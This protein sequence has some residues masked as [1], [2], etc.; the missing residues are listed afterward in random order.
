[1]KTYTK[2]LIYNFFKSFFLVFLITFCLIFILNL[3]TELDFFKQINVTN[4]FTMYLSLINTPSFIFEMFPFIFLISSQVFLINI[5]EHNQIEIFRYFGLKNIDILK[6][7][8]FCSFLVGI[9]I[10]LIF[11]NFSSSLKKIYLEL[12]TNYTSDNKY[13][14]VITN[15][16]LWIKDKIDNKILIINSLEIENNYLLNSFITEFDDNYKILRNIQS[17]KID[18]EYNT[19]KI[20]NAKVIIDNFTTEEKVLELKSNFDYQKIQTLF[21]NLTSLSI[22]E[23][24]ELKKNYEQLGYS[25]IEVDMHLNKL[26]VAPF[27]FMLMIFFSGTIM[28]YFKSK[29]NNTFKLSLGLFMS[30]LIYYYNNFFYVLGNTEKI[31]IIQSVWMP[32]IFL[33]CINQLM[34]KLI[35]S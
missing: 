14:A 25:T 11:Y 8:C 33:F 7:I 15:N 6:I 10:V 21:S 20:H 19:W 22:F 34:L 1:M 27:H 4:S 28:F 16:G 32:L 18:I 13:L 3:L 5:F 9:A 2:F 17:E 24:F 12:K 35:K 29:K 30:V 26:V 23:L 31:S